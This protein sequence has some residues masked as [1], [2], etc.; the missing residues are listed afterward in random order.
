[1]ENKGRRLVVDDEESICTVLA[2]TLKRE[3]YEV[4]TA[5]SASEG[6]AHFR[7]AFSSRPF[8]TILQDIRM[9]GI[10]G[11]DLIRQFQE[12][13]PSV[14]ILMITAL[15]DFQTAI[16]AMRRGAY[17]FIK[18][19]FDNE[20]DI[21]PAVERAMQLRRLHQNHKESPETFNYFKIIGTTSQMKEIYGLVRRVAATD[22][23]VLIQGESGTGKELIARSIHNQ[24]SRFSESFLSVN[25]GAFSENLLESELF[26]HVKGSFTSA[27]ADK[28]G[29]LEV[30]N[31]GTFFLDEV[32]ELSTALQVKLLRV[33]ETREFMPVGSTEHKR[34]DARFIAATN[35]DL[36]EQVKN[37]N[38]R[39]DLFYRLNVISI[40]LPPLRERKDDIPLLVGYFLAK[41]NKLMKKDIKGLA[42]DVMESLIGYSW[43]GNIRELENVIQRGMALTEG[44][45]ITSANLNLMPVARGKAT[46]VAGKEKPGSGD[47]VM[48]ALSAGGVNLRQKIED[49]ERN[50]IKAAL[51]QG[52]WN[53]SVAAR[54]LGLNIRTLRYKLKKHKLDK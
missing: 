45:M 27:I 28:K 37:G 13:D 29:L 51:Q 26:G 19:P 25:C 36:Q 11:L 43:P 2:S 14:I 1:M 22:S 31:K 17:D 34:A 9:P 8:D 54:L 40:M 32:S 39:E 3:G 10:S 52:K 38:F 44:A 16:E 47:A 50:Y 23:T 7:N 30:A 41:Y 46:P 20:I 53:Q 48:H 6:T 33:I 5:T 18:K 24:S 15:T 49:M 4:V 21:K 12:I 35:T 42:D